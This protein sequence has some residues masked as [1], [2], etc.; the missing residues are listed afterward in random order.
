MAQAAK[1]KKCKYCGKPYSTVRGGLINHERACA[2]NPDRVHRTYRRAKIDGE[3][4][5]VE[6][7][8][9]SFGRPVSSEMLDIAKAA[10]QFFPQGIK[11]DDTEALARTLEWLR[12]GAQLLKSK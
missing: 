4:P 5:P 2:A 1:R 9:Q 7:P 3:V 12:F 11:T 10:Q 6:T 8:G